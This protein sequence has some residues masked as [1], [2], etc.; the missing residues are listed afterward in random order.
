MNLRRRNADAK[1]VDDMPACHNNRRSRCNDLVIL[2]LTSLDSY[3]TCGSKL[4]ERDHANHSSEDMIEMCR[5]CSLPTGSAKAFLS[6]S[7]L[8]LR[9]TERSVLAR[10][11]KNARDLKSRCSA[12]AM[13][14]LTNQKSQRKVSNAQFSGQIIYGKSNSKSKEALRYTYILSLTPNMRPLYIPPPNPAPIYTHTYLNSLLR[15]LQQI[16]HFKVRIPT[17]KHI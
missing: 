3:S 5:I 4:Y 6:L 2:R 16:L 9:S 11:L 12:D 13:Q 1:H 15:L 17:L 10:V 7:G 14:Q 8:I